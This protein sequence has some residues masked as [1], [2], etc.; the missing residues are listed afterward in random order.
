MGAD[1][2]IAAVDARGTVRMPIPLGI[3]LAAAELVD[4][5]GARR[6]EAVDGRVRVTDRAPTGSPGAC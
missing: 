4:L 3:A 2:L 5:A 1:L 6:I